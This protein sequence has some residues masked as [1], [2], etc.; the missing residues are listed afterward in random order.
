MGRGEDV[1]LSPRPDGKEQN[2]E[3]QLELPDRRVHTSPPGFSLGDQMWD[4][5]MTEKTWKP[6]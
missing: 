6:E 3:A 1:P 4:W 5:W 2:K